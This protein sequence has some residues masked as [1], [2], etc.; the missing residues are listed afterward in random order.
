MNK[1]RAFYLQVS[2]FETVNVRTSNSIRATSASGR[3]HFLPRDIGGIF[4]L[5]IG[6]LMFYLI[7]GRALSGTIITIIVQ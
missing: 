6:L 1:Y 4:F 2:L 5:F 3:L 7:K